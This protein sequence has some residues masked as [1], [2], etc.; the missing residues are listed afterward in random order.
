MIAVEALSRRREQVAAEQADA[1][2]QRD[3]DLLELADV[4]LAG[5]DVDKLLDLQ[6]RLAL[7]DDDLLEWQR[8]VD[9][10]RRLAG[11]AM[12]AERAADDLRGERF[13]VAARKFAA[14]RA[15]RLDAPRIADA[16]G[17]VR[18]CRESTAE[19]QQL[20]ERFPSLFDR[21]GDV[22]RLRG[23]NPEQVADDA[24]AEACRLRAQRRLERVEREIATA[25]TYISRGGA[26]AEFWRHWQRTLR[27]DARR[28]TREL[29]GLAGDAVD[30]AGE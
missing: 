22:P 2:R 12:I 6:D 25:A 11:R 1:E 15:D 14:Q 5:H 19:L 17:H 28:L 30:D 8:A 21:S 26:D 4:L 13:R 23:D 27:A 3:A 7:S 29:D 24:H 10:G 20:A 9:R 16:E 18:D